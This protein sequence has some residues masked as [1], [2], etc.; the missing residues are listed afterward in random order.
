MEGGSPSSNILRE[1]WLGRWTRENPDAKY[2]RAGASVGEFAQDF[3]SSMIE[4]GSYLRL[5]TLSLAYTLPQRWTARRGLNAAR[6]YA[7]GANL[8]TWTN[9]SGFNPDVSSQGIGNVN[10]GIDTGAYPLART[11]TFGVSLTY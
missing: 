8:V 3:G 6:L 10:R 7:T 11:W 1:R 2:P 9:Y 5:R 4:D